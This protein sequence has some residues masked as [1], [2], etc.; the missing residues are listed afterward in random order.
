MKA[1]I[2]ITQSNR[3]TFRRPLEGSKISLGRSSRCDISLPEEQQLQ[4]E[5]LLIIPEKTGCQVELA[6]QAPT[7]FSF[8]GQPMQKGLIPWGEDIYV[9]KIRFRMVRGPSKTDR[10]LINRQFIFAVFPLLCASAWLLLNRSPAD[11]SSDP[12][13]VVASPL[14]N[15][16]IE[17]TQPR[18]ALHRAGE[19]ERA[20]F[21]KMERYPYVYQDGVEAVRLMSE[22]RN[23]YQAAGDSSQAARVQK[24]LDTWTR[25]LEQDYRSLRL[26]LRLALADVQSDEARRIVRILR[27]LLSHRDDSY[28]QWLVRVEQRLNAH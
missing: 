3:T 20:A 18:L 9:D 23:C 2:E 5:H 19:A 24:A 22:S 4:A 21:A 12:G 27:D 13:N 16:P 1:F 6:S 15:P 25:R 14:F 17:C 28:T 7:S 10:K 8:Q 11:D 26:R